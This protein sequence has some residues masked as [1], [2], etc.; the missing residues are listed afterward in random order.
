MILAAD[1]ITGSS[2]PGKQGDHISL[3]NLIVV[4]IGHVVLAD[5][6]L[7]DANKGFFLGSTAGHSKHVV[8]IN[9]GTRFNHI[10]KVTSTFNVYRDSGSA[11]MAS[12]RASMQGRTA[13]ATRRASSFGFSYISLGNKED[14]QC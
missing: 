12:K 8:L 4:R 3:H 11:F 9:C 5:S 14:L 6:L 2:N 13:F 10:T 1:Q 7:Q